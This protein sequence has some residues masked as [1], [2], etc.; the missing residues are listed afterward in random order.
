MSTTSVSPSRAGRSVGGDE[1]GDGVAQRL[2]LLRDELLGHLGLGPADLELSPVDDLDLGLHGHGR[3]EPPGGAVLGRE[4]VLVLRLR[5]GTDAGASGGV[6]EPAGDVAVDRLRV[7]PLLAEPLYEH[8]R[9][10]PCRL[11][12]RG[13]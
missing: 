12:S 11:G 8:R 1:L 7:D 10:A 5:D 6:P 13:S 3:L 4:V 9:A 2:E